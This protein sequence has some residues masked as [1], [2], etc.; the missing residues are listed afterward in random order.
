MPLPE[1]LDELFRLYRRY[2]PVIAGLSVLLVVPGLLTSLL[3]GSYRSN[4]LGLLITYV[5]SG[6]T[7]V[8]QR[9]QDLQAQ[10][11]PGWGLLGGLIGLIIVP[12]VAAGI[13]RAAIDAAQGQAITIGSVLRGIL[14]RYW[15]V[16][17]YLLLLGLIFAGITI[18]WAVTFIVP[19]IGLLLVFAWLAVVCWLGVRWAVGLPALLAEGIG[20]VRAMRRSWN[21]VSGMWWRTFGILL[22]TGLVYVVITLA[23]FALFGGIAALI[24]ALSE[25]VRSAIA[26]AGTALSDALIAPVFPILLTLLYFDLRVRKEGLDLDQLARETSPGPAPA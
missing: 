24:P 9:I 5:N 3:S 17:G 11:N 15:A 4:S 13:Y 14:A 23:L 1:L 6:S 22:L 12:F 7:A 18:V 16:W 10:Q 20:P 26:T 2:F 25:D 19:P 8:L 21:L